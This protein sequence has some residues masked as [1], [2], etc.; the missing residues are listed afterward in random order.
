MTHRG[1]LAGFLL[2]LRA[3]QNRAL[4]AGSH[5]AESRETATPEGC[6]KTL[7]V[8][9]SIGMLWADRGGRIRRCCSGG[10]RRRKTRGLFPRV[11]RKDGP[12]AAAASSEAGAQRWRRG[13][14][15]AGLTANLAPA[16]TFA[17]AREESAW[18]VLGIYS[19]FVWLIF[20][21]LKWLPWN[22]MT[23]SPSPSSRS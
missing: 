7:R 18:N 2:F 1:G 20:I 4:L 23:Q 6:I 3:D 17:P 21:K 8:A 5:P 13:T 22:T 11:G 14:L 15:P 9:R 10:L 16:S 12:D 19:F